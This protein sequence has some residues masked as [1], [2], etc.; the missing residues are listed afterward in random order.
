MKQAW[1]IVVGAAVGVLL[2][3]TYIYPGRYIYRQSGTEDVV[4]VD[5][6]TGVKTYSTDA[7]W[8]TEKEM[9]AEA[10][11]DT[12]KQ[13][14]EWLRAKKITRWRTDQTTL[15]VTSTYGSTRSLAIDFS[16][17]LIDELWT[18]VEREVD[19]SEPLDMGASAPLPDQGVR[20]NAPGV[21]PNG[22]PTGASQGMAPGISPDSAAPALERGTSNFR[23]GGPVGESARTRSK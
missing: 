4:R 10:V 19:S 15:Y 1:G 22:P 9:L 8:R 23:P 5:R 11:G 12:R 17:D 3:G 6:M 13:I 18:K 14:W 16:D 20:P 7:G 21:S 2:I